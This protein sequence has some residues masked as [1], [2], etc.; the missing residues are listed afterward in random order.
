MSNTYTEPA[1]P[2]IELEADVAAKVTLT[3]ASLRLRW[4]E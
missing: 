1:R 4:P 3:A 2:R